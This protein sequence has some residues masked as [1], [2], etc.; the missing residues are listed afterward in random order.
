MYNVAPADVAILET[1]DTMIDQADAFPRCQCGN[2][3]ITDDPDAD[4]CVEC[5]AEAAETF[6]QD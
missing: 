1:D 6:F 2:L 4:Q 5:A 3:I